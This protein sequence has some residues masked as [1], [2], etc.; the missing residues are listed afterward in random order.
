M[1]RIYKERGGR[2]YRLINQ[3]RT[4]VREKR[5]KEREE[6]GTIKEMIVCN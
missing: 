2:G 6:G 3:F 1:K 5:E 4:D